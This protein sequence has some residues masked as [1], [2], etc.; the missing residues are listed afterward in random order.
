MQSKLSCPF[1]FLYSLRHLTK[2]ETLP[3]NDKGPCNIT[4]GGSDVDC[5]DSVIEEMDVGLRTC[6]CNVECNELDYK[7]S[8]SQSSW[9]SKQYEVLS[10][11]STTI[12]GDTSRC[13]KP[14]VAK[15]ELLFSSQQEVLDNVM[16]HPVLF[17]NKI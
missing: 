6:M 11:F 13:P 14:P 2:A 12:Q 1:P 17:C 8:I 9:P 10:R 4:T 15:T 7:L 5:V 16:C 3:R